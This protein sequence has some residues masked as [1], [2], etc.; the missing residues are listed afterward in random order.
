MTIMG[1]WDF[2]DKMDHN[3]H[4]VKFHGVRGATLNRII[5][6]SQEI[7]DGKV[8][9]WGRAWSDYDEDHEDE[10]LE[11]VQDGGVLY[12]TQYDDLS[13]SCNEFMDESGAILMLG[14]RKGINPKVEYQGP[15]DREHVITLSE[16][17]IVG[18]I[19]PIY[20]DEYQYEID[21]DQ[22]DFYSVEEVLEGAL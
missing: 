15:G 6:S 20:A 7:G 4:P 14:A 2:A 13:L 1:F 19:R 22:V 9:L 5:E 17:E 3:H 18:A 12:T 11:Y 16:W 21:E 10:P 8:H